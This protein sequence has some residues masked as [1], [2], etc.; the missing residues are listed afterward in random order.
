[1]ALTLRQWR[2]ARE[3]T[4]EQMA[5]AL[6]IHI[7]TYQNWEKDPGKISVTNVM[8]IAE[9]LKVSINDIIFNSEPL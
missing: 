8:K 1:M 2:K 9:V 5:K 4:Q 3:I 6:N 7:N